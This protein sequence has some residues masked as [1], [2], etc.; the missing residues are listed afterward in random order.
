MRRPVE[1]IPK[2]QNKN[3]ND[4]RFSGRLFY[5]MA[6]KS[7]IFHIGI[8]VQGILAL[9]FLKAPEGLRFKWGG[10]QNS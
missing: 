4:A 6:R 9:V 3:K 2:S 10:P 8:L 5:K 7:S 1:W